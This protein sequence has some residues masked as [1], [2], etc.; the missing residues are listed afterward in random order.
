MNQ[1]DVYK[2]SRHLGATSK[3]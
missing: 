3:F 1:A 2:F